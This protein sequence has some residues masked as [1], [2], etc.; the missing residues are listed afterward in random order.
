[1]EVGT[2]RCAVPARVPAGG[3]NVVACPPAVVLSFYKTGERARLGRSGGRPRPPPRARQREQSRLIIYTLAFGISGDQPLQNKGRGLRA[4]Y[5]DKAIF[6]TLH[7]L[8]KQ[9]GKPP[10]DTVRAFIAVK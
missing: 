10:F 8:R 5:L 2:A 6:E 1:M 7:K 4:R 3:P 9:E